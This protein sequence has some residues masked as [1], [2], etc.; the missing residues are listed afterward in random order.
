MKLLT[1]NTSLEL[2]CH[3]IW[4]AI[5]NVR[6]HVLKT[7]HPSLLGGHICGPA[8]I[9]RNPQFICDNGRYLTKCNMEDVNSVL[10]SPP[11]NDFEN[12]SVGL[13]FVFKYVVRHLS[14]ATPSRTK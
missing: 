2:N 14:F 1:Q 7:I 12:M 8:S 5:F 9:I 4:F 3:T 6:I 10:F 13:I 11:V